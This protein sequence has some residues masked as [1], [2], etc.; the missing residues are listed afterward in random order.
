MDQTSK[1]DIAASIAASFGVLVT[2]FTLGYSS[3][4]IMPLQ[5]EG[6]LDCNDTGLFASLFFLGAMFGSIFA[7][8]VSNQ[9]GRKATLLLCFLP[10]VIGWFLIVSAYNGTQLII[11][12]FL[13]GVSGAMRVQ[14]LSV[15]TVEMAVKSRRGALSSLLSVLANVGILLI[16]VFGLFLSWR[17]MAVVAIFVTLMSVLFVL[18][19]PDT[20]RW[21][22]LKGRRGEAI[23]V[24]SWLYERDNVD[25]DLKE[26]EEN[27]QMF[28]SSMWHTLFDKH[29]KHQIF[30]SVCI[31]MMNQ[32]SGKY[33]LVAYQNKIF[34]DVGFSSP[35]LP[36]IFI[37][38]VSAAFSIASSFIVD[39][40]GRRPLY[41]IAGAIIS[42]S[43]L[44]LGVCF[45]L[46][47]VTTKWIGTVC[48]VTY[49]IGY[50]VS[51]GT[52]SILISSEIYPLKSRGAGAGLSLLSF[53]FSG[54]IVTLLFP[55]L[56]AI[57]HEYGMFWIF[58][59]LCVIAT[60]VI[61]I[62]MPET[63]GKSLEEIELYF[64]S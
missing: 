49:N 55:Q 12:R 20:P 64:A 39:R 3:P 35:N 58:G 14:S 19:W 50:S 38:A 44:L 37:A 33:V 28:Q 30:L 34:S 51:W 57:I 22:L 13:T 41:I 4:V 52:V 53:W 61:P 15:Y 45:Y 27:L 60:I 5:K 63:K 18:P 54:F 42:V 6:I 59:I 46:D 47:T 10:E 16:Y 25:D 2:G 36:S 32:L 26:I 24:L 29:L 40:M 62:C 31:M 8:S 9:I 56:E 11:G 21:Y 7:G 48:F 17:W 43:L 1:R 23:A